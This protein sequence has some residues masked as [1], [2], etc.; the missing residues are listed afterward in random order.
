MNR[1]RTAAGSLVTAFSTYSKIPMPRIKWQPEYGKYVPAF[2]PAV[3]IVTGALFFAVRFAAD[4]LGIGDI[5]SGALL[6]A[7]PIAVS[8]GIHA[9]GFAD[10]ADALGSWGSRDKKLEIMSDPR[11]GAFAVIWSILY[12]LLFFAAA[13]SL[14]SAAQTVTAAAGF[15]MSRA[16]SS[17]AASVLP[18]AKKS[19]MLYAFK[20]ASAKKICTAASVLWFL[21]AAFVMAAAGP[22][23]AACIVCACAL[24]Y[25]LYRHMALKNFGGVTG[26]TA[27]YLLQTTELL[28][29]MI[30]ALH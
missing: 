16:V 29:I 25:F 27:G 14:K 3:G 13:A 10:T 19:G 20:Q 30:C 22:V 11:S 9:D 17:F 24:R 6:T 8:G 28:I 23:R 4:R 5:Y 12:F 18:S 15:V 21:Q 7:V 26:D 2:F 1:I